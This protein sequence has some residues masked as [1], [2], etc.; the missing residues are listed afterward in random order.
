MKA[1]KN[2]LVIKMSSLGD[3]L[4]SLPTLHALRQNCPDA[5]IVWAVHRQFAS[6]LPGK[7]YI[8]DVIYVD[9]KRLKSLSYWMELRKTLHPYHFDLCLDLQGLAKSAI[10]AFLSGAKEKYGYWEMREG[11]FLVSKGLVG[12]HKYDHVIERYLDTIRA[13]GGRV[14]DLVFPLPD[15]MAEKEAW[16]QRLLQD[17]LKGPYIAVVPGAR[18]NV[19][20]WP[21]DHWSRFLKHLTDKG[22]S[23]VILGGNDDREKGR[24]LKEQDAS[25]LVFDY[26]GKTDL[27]QLMA[28]IDDSLVYLSADTGPLHIANALK[29][30]LI[31]LFGTTSP[32]RTGPYGGQDSAYIHLVISPTSKATPEEP[33]VDDPDCMAQITVDTVWNLFEEVLKKVE[34]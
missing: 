25:G 10:V 20:E 4:H 32:E 28:A 30:E 33:L 14:D 19:K 26:T 6:V 21:L 3:V 1:Y 7:P 34:P 12:A 9:K 16:R 8:D 5:R 23:A 27:R 31:A 13:L 17:G 2:I 22:L 15:I 24:R 11:S 18:W 29:K